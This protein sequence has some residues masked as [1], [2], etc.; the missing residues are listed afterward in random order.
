MIKGLTEELEAELLQFAK[1]RFAELYDKKKLLDENAV[2]WLA[3]FHAIPKGEV[4][5]WQSDIF[6]PYGFSQVASI[7]PRLKGSLFQYEDFIEVISKQQ[8][9]VSSEQSIRDY[10]I[11]YFEEMAFKRKASDV[12]D[13]AMPY[14]TGWVKVVTSPDGNQIRMSTLDFF[15]VIPEFSQKGDR[16]NDFSD[17]FHR[18]ESNINAVRLKET[19]G[20]YKNVEKLEDSEF[21]IDEIIESQIKVQGYSMGIDNL[22]ADKQKSKSDSL[23]KVELM[24]WWGKYDVNGDGEDEDIVITLGNREVLLRVDLNTDGIIPIFPIRPYRIPR[25]TFGKSFIQLVEGLQQELNTKRNQFMDVLNLILKPWFKA[26]RSSE[27]D[28]DNLFGTPNNVIRMD[29]TND[30]QPFEMKAPPSYMFNT[31]TLIKNDIQTVLGASDVN[32]GGGAG[33]RG[34]NQTATGISQLASEGATRFRDYLED[35]HFDFIQIIEYVLFLIK[36]YKRDHKKVR[37]F[38]SQDWENITAKAL[39]GK[40]RV[41]IN[42]APFVQNKEL[43]MQVLMN[44]A[45]TLGELI[46]VKPV[47]RNILELAEVKYIDEV[48][49]ENKREQR[50]IATAEASRNL[51]TPDASADLPINTILQNPAG[52]SPLNPS[53]PQT[54]QNPILDL[55]RNTAGG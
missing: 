9:Y 25:L 19:Q 18:I 7:S 26:R 44:L 46:D 11:S 21:P 34:F 50:K 36:K 3:D 48:L 40:Y 53:A 12:I 8:E 42:L 6:I 55:I 14:G 5:A 47:A 4:E 15:D 1:D 49:G 10:L 2:E 43:R 38:N 22:S 54:V 23:N 29:D 37:I 41:R 39:K 16:S 27:I 51:N 17:C 52:V 45:N 35:L 33:G 32:L 13:D 30:V 20:V 28:W 24:E 31:E